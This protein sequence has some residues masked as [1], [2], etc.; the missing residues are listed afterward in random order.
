MKQLLAALLTALCFAS[1]CGATVV[2]LVKAQSA[3]GSA[4]T[5]TITLSGVIAGDFVWVGV[6]LGSNQVSPTVSDS[7]GN[8]VLGAG[9]WG[10]NSAGISNGEFYVQSASAGTN[11]FTIVAASATY[12]RAFAAEYAGSYTYDTA[13]SPNP[14]N[15]AS[16][17]TNSVTPGA[18]GELAIALISTSFAGLT[19]SAWTN[20]FVQE[21]TYNTSGTSGVWADLSSAGSGAITAS[22]TMSAAK[23]YVASLALFRA[24]GGST[25]THAGIT[26]AGAIAVPNGTSGS[27]RLKNGSFGT[28]DCSTVSYKQTIGNFGVN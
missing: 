20:S 3:N 24:S 18:S 4:T 9:S 10:G 22:A 19:F 5:I 25:C 6:Y 26:S 1:P 11:T 8:T 14:G 15:S 12:I 23:A 16:P 17:T 2:Q 13:A 7:N 27:Y 28:P 21:D